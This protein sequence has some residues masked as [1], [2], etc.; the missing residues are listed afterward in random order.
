MGVPGEVGEPNTEH[1]KVCEKLVYQADRL[2]CDKVVYHK[3]CFKCTH[4]N[5]RLKLGD[6][7]ALDGKLYCKPHY[8][9]LFK[10]KGNY[11]SSFENAGKGT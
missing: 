4:C 11:S 7:T 2:V 9:Q 5:G 1:C 3:Q 10:L 8:T 6:F